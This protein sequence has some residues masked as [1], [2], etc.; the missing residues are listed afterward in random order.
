VAAQIVGAARPDDAGDVLLTTLAAAHASAA[1]C[2]AIDAPQVA[3]SLRGRT[4]DI[5]LPDLQVR[6]RAWSSHHACGCAWAQAA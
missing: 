3:S 6:H 5:A 1:V 2:A 4:L